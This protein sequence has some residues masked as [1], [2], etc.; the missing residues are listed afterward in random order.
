MQQNCKE[1]YYSI[2]WAFFIDFLN[3][4]EPSRVLVSTGVPMLSLS[5]VGY[6]L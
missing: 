1:L 5:A 4:L 2:F 6:W 3:H